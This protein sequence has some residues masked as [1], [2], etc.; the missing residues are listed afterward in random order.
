MNLAD[1]FGMLEPEAFDSGARARTDHGLDGRLAVARLGRAGFYSVRGT[2][3]IVRRTSR[4]IAAAPAD[5]LKL[6]IQLRGSAVVQQSDREVLIE[7]G[8][9]ALYDT[10][11]PYDLRLSGPWACAV[12]TVPRESLNVSNRALATAMGHPFGVHDGPGALLANL[13]EFALRQA[14]TV[15]DTTSN[16]HLG[17]AGIEL[18]AALLDSVPHNIEGEAGRVRA[19]VLTYIRA[20][21]RDSDLSHS[22]VAAAHHMSPRTLNRIFEGQ[23]RTVTDAIRMLRLEAVQ[24]ELGNPRRRDVSVMALASRWGF[25]DQGHF[26]RTF[27]AQFGQ[28]PAAFRRATLGP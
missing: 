9:L 11:R 26:T 7:P 12:V 6:C 1:A 10:A 16:A 18:V 5:S 15:D 2:P 13:T 21:L 25:R 24:T 4:S 17:E 27:K 8:Q 23:D 20:H 28:T 14:N 22:S 19:V 3:Q